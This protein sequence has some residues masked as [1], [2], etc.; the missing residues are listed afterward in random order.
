MDEFIDKAVKT[1]RKRYSKKML[2]DKVDFFESLIKGLT[3]K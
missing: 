3:A 1:L 2:K